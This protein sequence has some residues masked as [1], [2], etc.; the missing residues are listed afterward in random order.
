VKKT[1]LILGCGDVG[2]ALARELLKAGQHVIGVRRDVSKLADLGIETLALD[3]TAEGALASLPDADTV[4]HV[5]SADRF[6]EEAYRAAY[7]DGIRA[8]VA[9]LES[10][11]KPPTRVLFV[12]STSVY[13]QKDGEEVDE[14]SP[15]DATSFSGQLM[16]EGEQALLD[17]SL[18]GTVVRFSGIYGPGRDML[19]RQAR[20]G[21]IAASN[22]PLYSNRIHRD[23]CAGVL[24]HLIALSLEGKPVE[25]IY[26]ATD[27]DGAPLHEVM[28]WLAR[29]LKVESTEVIQSPLRRRSSKRCGNALLL[30]SGYTFRY[31]TFREG[32]AEVLKEHGVTVPKS[33]LSGR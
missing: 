9:E 5:L 33:E 21:R 11:A 13:A 10:R 16:R 14:Q 23:D 19:I 27:C 15:T 31:P 4:V 26:L 12:S 20:D 1:S 6:D 24:A 18:N 25:P 17:S 2:S 29:Q 7:V 30:E 22:P 32:Y 28:A 3:I 8:L